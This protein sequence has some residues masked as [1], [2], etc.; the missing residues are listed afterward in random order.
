MTVNYKDCFR[1]MAKAGMLIFFIVQLVVS[2][3]VLLAFIQYVFSLLFDVVCGSACCNP[4]AT[5]WT[6]NAKKGDGEV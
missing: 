5:N 1:G 6:G 2:L 4:L 3:T